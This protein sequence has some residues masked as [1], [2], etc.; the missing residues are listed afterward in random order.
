MTKH[1]KTIDFRSFIIIDEPEKE[2]CIVFKQYFALKII[3]SGSVF[4]SC[5][6]SR[7]V[8]ADLGAVLSITPVIPPSHK[9]G[10]E[11]ERKVNH[12]TG[13]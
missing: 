13:M 1:S 5:A 10:S 7:E 6:R 4:F 11:E 3:T 12:F 2:D 9:Q 8:H